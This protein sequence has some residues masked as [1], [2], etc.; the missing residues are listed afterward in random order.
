MSNIQ[1]T[2]V[3]YYGQMQVKDGMIV[4]AKTNKPMQVYG[5]SFFWSNWS[6]KYYTADYVDLMVDEF[7][8]EIVRCAYGIGNNG[9]PCNK[10]CVPLIE[11]VIEQSIKRGIYVILDWHSHGAHENPAEAIKFFSEMARKYGSYDNVIFEL[12]NEPL[13]ANWKQIKAYAE[14][15]IPEI[16]KYSDNLIIVGTPRWSQHV[17]TAA[18]FPID[19]PNV[20]YALHFYAGTHKK[21]L[22]DRADVAMKQGIALFVSE[23]GSVNADG[24]GAISKISTSKWLKWMDEHLLSGCTWAI[25]DKKEG[26]SIFTS[27]SNISNTGIYIKKI[28]SDRSLKA[29]WRGEI[30]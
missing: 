30:E 25:S 23:W 10:K 17:H 29:P 15:V 28:I 19:D 7:N 24:N 18:K 22:R 20:A 11:N 16:R 12:Y 26:S 4:G 21:R 27:G 9:V 6:K 14:L 13:K 1:N 5:M 3:G 8:C 2:P